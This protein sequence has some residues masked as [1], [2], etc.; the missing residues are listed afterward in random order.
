M[1][2]APRGL[3]FSCVLR[4]NARSLRVGHGIVNTQSI[5]VLVADDDEDQRALLEGILSAADWADYRVTSVPD[6]R[7]ALGALREQVFDVALLDLSMPGLDGL[8]VLEALGDDS[9]RP[10]DLRLGHGH[11]GLGDAGHEAGGLRLPGEADPAG[12]AGGARMEGRRG[13][14]V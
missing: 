13:P 2:L 1:V 8:E 9:S 5:A 7:S 14:Q 12:A 3:L 4:L 11:G 10:G 6:G